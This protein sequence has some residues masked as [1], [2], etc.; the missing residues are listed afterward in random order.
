MSN[1]E[2]GRSSAHTYPAFRDGLDALLAPDNVLVPGLRRPTH[3]TSVL[4]AKH[5]DRVHP[6]GIDMLRPRLGWTSRRFPV[7]TI[8]RSPRRGPSPSSCSHG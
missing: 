2:S 7:T 5:D 1:A 4:L 6:A 8:C 3:P